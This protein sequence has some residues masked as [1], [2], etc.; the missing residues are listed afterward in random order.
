MANFFKGYISQNKPNEFSSAF[1][2]V[3]LVQRV[4]LQFENLLEKKTSKKYIFFI[5]PG[6]YYLQI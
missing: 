2:L 4:H 3:H 1:N 6:K 5:N